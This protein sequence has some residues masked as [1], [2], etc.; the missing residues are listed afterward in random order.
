VGTCGEWSRRLGFGF[1]G[2]SLI[3]STSSALAGSINIV[4]AENFYGDIAKQIGG[5]NVTVM[6]IL[7]NP[8][9][10]P[11]LFEVSPSVGRDV[12]AAPIV[13]Y[14]GIDY[15][16]W[17]EKLLDAARSSNRKTIVVAGLVGKKIGDNPH[18]WYDPVTVSALA[19][20]LSEILIAEDP[21]DKGGYEQRLAQFDESLKPIL[22]K[23]ADLRQRFA[24]TPVTAT[25]PIFGYMFDALGMDVRNQA[26]QL[27]VMNNT[28]P[29][30]S[31]IAG[32]ESDLETH[33][34]KLLLYNSQATDPIADR[35]KKFAK[36][37]GVPVIGTTETEP[38]GE[39]YQSW[40][41]SALDAVERA[42]PKQAP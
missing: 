8:D 11:H 26:F 30:A 20:R 3:A 38:A 34:V 17:M 19:K 39:N 36:G 42:L 1:F 16:P 25:E 6:S 13:I 28:E 40:M 35:M 23:I 14:N 24:G 12:S 21:A 18:I 4:A 10:D 33:R 22:A 2:L 37:A 15:D 27:A 9:Q 7:N 31:D 32:F 5:P 41:M 29:S